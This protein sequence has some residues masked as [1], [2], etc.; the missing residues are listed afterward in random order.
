MGSRSLH[1]KIRSWID[2]AW[3]TLWETS[4]VAEFLKMRSGSLI[5]EK[6]LLIAERLFLHLWRENEN[7][8]SVHLRGWD[9]HQTLVEALNAPKCP[10]I[11][12]HPESDK[13]GRKH[14]HTSCMK[15][16][17]VFTGYTHLGI[18]WW[19]QRNLASREWL[20]RKW[21][22]RM[23]ALNLLAKNERAGAAHVRWPHL[24]SCRHARTHG[25][26]LPTGP[27]PRVCT[28]EERLEKQ[29][30]L[31]LSRRKRTIFLTLALWQE[32]SK[33]NS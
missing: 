19:E 8:C 30:P 31:S 29:G 25:W 22:I 3:A 2:V 23:I 28:S 9:D 4:H 16:L 5:L 6:C 11:V 10:T 17:T 13:G 33:E 26:G 27:K 24:I 1:F 7:P 12:K 20:W 18:N 15:S 21:L 32:N 14:S